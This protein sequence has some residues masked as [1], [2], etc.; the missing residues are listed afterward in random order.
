MD[1]MKM[2]EEQFTKRDIPDFSVGDTVKVLTKIAEGDKTRLHPFEGVIICI[3]KQGVRSTFTVRRI[4]FGEGVERVFP[5]HSPNIE[6]IEIIKRAKAGRSK[7]YYLR[8]RIG[9]AASKV[10]DEKKAEV[11]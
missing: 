4:S 9:K 1:K 5:F 3:K 11:K 7:L 8:G 2:I 6:R 10:E